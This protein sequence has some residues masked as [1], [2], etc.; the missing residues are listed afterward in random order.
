MSY[1]AIALISSVTA[2]V[3]GI[4]LFYLSKYI[5]KRVTRQGDLNNFKDEL[6][7]NMLLLDFFGKNVEEVLLVM[8][9]KAEDFPSFD[10]SRI[11]ETFFSRC[12]RQGSLYTCLSHEE[13]FSLSRIYSS[14]SKERQKMLETYVADAFTK[15]STP[16]KVEAYYLTAQKQFFRHR[17]TLQ[18]LLQKL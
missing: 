4:G 6:K 9:R 18:S 10:F 2:L 8:Q 12:L 15:K 16:Q 11:E 13:I 7:Y 17:D 1:I 14:L 3:F 5:D